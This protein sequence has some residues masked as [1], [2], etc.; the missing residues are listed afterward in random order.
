MRVN[1]DER[2]LT[3]EDRRRKSNG[4]AALGWPSIR[5]IAHRAGQCGNLFRSLVA[6]VFFAWSVVTLGGGDET[7]GF[8]IMT[9]AIHQEISVP[10]HGRLPD[11]VDNDVVPLPLPACL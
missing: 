5:P 2:T 10:C 9:T 6:H 7:T 11:C 1:V 4:A 3:H 8:E